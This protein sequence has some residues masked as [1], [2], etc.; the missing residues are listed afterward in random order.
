M[1]ILHVVHRYWP[2]HGGSEQYMQFLSEY[3]AG[4]GHEVSVWTTDAL[5]VESLW[6]RGKTRI[7]K[8]EETLNG[9]HI[10]RFPVSYFPCHRYV[11]RLLSYL[12]FGRWRFLYAPGSPHV[13]DIVREARIS[14]EPFDIVHVTPFPY[15]SLLYAA[16][17][18]AR[19]KGIP[20]VC[21]PFIHLGEGPGSPVRTHYSRPHQIEF[22]RGA[23][24]VLAQ[25]RR[26]IQFLEQEGLP[27]SKIHLGGVGVYLE[28]LLGGKSARFRAEYGVNEPIVAFIGVRCQD[29]GTIHLIRSCQ[30][31][32]KSGKDFRLV[33]LGSSV[34]EFDAE[35]ADLPD[36]VKSKCLMIDD[37]EDQC[38]RDLL[39][40]MDLLALP[41]RTDS[42]G[43]VILEAWSYGRPVIAADA[44]GPGEVV[45]D[46]LDG[47]LVPYGDTVKLGEC[48]AYLLDNVAKRKELGA[49]GQ[50]RIQ[51][52]FLWESV[53]SRIE[54]LYYDLTT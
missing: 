20:L 37:P 39:D 24:A 49:T 1:K 35:F 48:I 19:R 3:L 42:F 13:P 44:G 26:E 32:W 45:R 29:K 5:S 25:T 14:Q 15:D 4:R 27:A 31:L 2:A 18:V 30:D 22:L 40:A 53:L 34:R 10:R 9:V 43:I 38:K 23:S 16:A 52:E 33:L 12:R 21:T 41:S 11:M 47:L 54:S 8:P 46:G 17:V 28:R 50:A 51:T 7:D 6:A 36:D